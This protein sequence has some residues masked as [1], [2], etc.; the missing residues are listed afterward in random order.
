M[1]IS[2]EQFKKDAVDVEDVS[3][4]S[5]CDVMPGRIYPGGVYIERCHMDAD[6]EGPPNA[7]QLTIGN[8][9]WTHIGIEPSDD[10]VTTL[11]AFALSEELI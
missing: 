9:G 5:G 4:W 3:P 7:W 11:Y 2:I 10:M 1:R 8:A 6:P